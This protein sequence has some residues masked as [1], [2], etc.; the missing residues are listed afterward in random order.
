MRGW[1]AH[2]LAHGAYWKAHDALGTIWHC[3]V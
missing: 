2:H 3:G 1:P